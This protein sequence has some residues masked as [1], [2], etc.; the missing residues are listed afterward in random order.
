MGSFRAR[1]EVPLSANPCRDSCFRYDVHSQIRKQAAA[2]PNDI[3]NTQTYC[4]M[5]AVEER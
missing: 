5:N 3:T 2:F 1:S 4:V